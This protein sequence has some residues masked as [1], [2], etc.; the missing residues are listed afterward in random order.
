MGKNFTIYT[1]DCEKGI[2]I[3]SSNKV[4]LQELEYA[5][6]KLKP[7]SGSVD[8]WLGI[9]EE[10]FFGADNEDWAPGDPVIFMPW[11]Q[12]LEILGRVPKGTA[13]EF[14]K[15]RGLEH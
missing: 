7:Y 1:P 14:M 2:K 12:V 13:G 6:S 9:N 10:G 3:L 15:A 8:F 11:V 5:I 4:T